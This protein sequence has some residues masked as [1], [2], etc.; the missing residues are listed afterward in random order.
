MTELWKIFTD[1]LTGEE[2][3]R[4]TMDGTFEG[5]EEA[6]KELLAYEHGISVDCIK[7]VVKAERKF[8]IKP[9]HLEKWGSMATE[10]TLID[11][12]EVENLSKEWGI[13]AEELMTQLA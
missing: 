4:Y 7:T 11:S 13:S 1:R 12:A 9:Q 6:T 5:E 10:E 2:Y 8:R 3:A